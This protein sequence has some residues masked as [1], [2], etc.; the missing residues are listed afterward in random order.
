MDTANSTLEVTWADGP[1]GR[2]LEERCMK[3]EEKMLQVHVFVEEDA[4][5]LYSAQSCCT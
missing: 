4:L 3:V 1:Q 2:D 5:R